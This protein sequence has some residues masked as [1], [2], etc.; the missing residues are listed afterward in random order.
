MG[1]DKKTFKT[2][3]KVKEKYSEEIRQKM[4]EDIFVIVNSPNFNEDKFSLC[5]S[6]GF[7]YAFERINAIFELKEEKRK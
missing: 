3:S 6:A 2:I 5:W 7:S 1:K 4:T